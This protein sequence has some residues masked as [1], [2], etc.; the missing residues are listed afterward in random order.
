MSNNIVLGTELK[1]KSTFMSDEEFEGKQKEIEDMI[2][3]FYGKDFNQILFEFDEDCVRINYNPNARY[4]LCE[5]KKWWEF[6]K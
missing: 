3:D 5:P 2:R 4:I 1:M 6:W